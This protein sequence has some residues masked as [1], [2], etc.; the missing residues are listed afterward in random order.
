MVPL[1]FSF[2]RYNFDCQ[3]TV[4]KKKLDSMHVI[5]EQNKYTVMGTAELK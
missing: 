2:F 3:N 4:P 5:Q 1:L